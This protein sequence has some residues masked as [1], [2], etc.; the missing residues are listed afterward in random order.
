MGETD[1]SSD[2]EKSDDCEYGPPHLDSVGDV[3]TDEQTGDTD[4]SS[5]DL[6]EDSGES[7]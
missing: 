5:R 3:N 1:G 4:S 7:V 6:H 2:R